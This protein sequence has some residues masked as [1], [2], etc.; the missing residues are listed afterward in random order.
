MEKARLQAG[1]CVHE[2]DQKPKRSWIIEVFDGAGLTG[3]MR[4]EL[5][6]E[7]PATCRTHKEHITDLSTLRT[8]VVALLG[9]LSQIN[10]M[11]CVCKFGPLSLLACIFS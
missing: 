11:V 3:V 4:Q 2:V 6:L 7:G 5:M 9:K 10:C 1:S 8:S